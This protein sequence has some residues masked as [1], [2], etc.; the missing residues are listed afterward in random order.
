MNIRKTKER[1]GQLPANFN[2]NQARFT[3]APNSFNAARDA[4]EAPN[5]FPVPVANEPIF[6]PNTLVLAQQLAQQEVNRQLAA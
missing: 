4:Q 2:L 3:P 6:D 1:L 5:A